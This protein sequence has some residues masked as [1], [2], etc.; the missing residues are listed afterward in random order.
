MGDVLGGAFGG[1]I[2]DLKGALEGI[3]GGVG[4]AF[5]AV[6]VASAV[7]VG[8]VS[9]ASAVF[10]IAVSVASAV[11]VIAA[12]VAL[13]CRVCR[14]CLCCSA[15]PLLELPAFS[16]SAGLARCGDWLLAGVLGGAGIQ[17]VLGGLLKGDAGKAVG[18]LFGG[19]EGIGGVIN[20]VV[21]MIGNLIGGA[22]TAFLLTLQSSLSH[23]ALSAYCSQ[24]L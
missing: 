6:S 4:G 1:V 15:L 17:D 11:F 8:A 2:G 14:S 10:V 20:N 21:G 22:Y 7:F 12:S 18:G 23:T 24:T 5:T 13:R 3:L 9:V 16:A 19:K